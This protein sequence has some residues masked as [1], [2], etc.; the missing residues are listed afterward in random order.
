MPEQDMNEHEKHAE[1]G[2][3]RYQEWR[4][5]LLSTPE[6]R[7]MYE[8]EG[9]KLD[10]WLASEERKTKPAHDSSRSHIAV[11][12][13]RSLVKSVKGLYAKKRGSD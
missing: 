6:N 4:N 12:G 13:S 9:E 11:S 1:E 2:Q 5:K 8:E 10:E 7:K 3:R